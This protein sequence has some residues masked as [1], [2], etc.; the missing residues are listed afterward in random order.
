MSKISGPFFEIS[1]IINERY[2]ILKEKKLFTT[3]LIPEG[4]NLNDYKNYKFDNTV[5]VYLKN[6]DGIK[7][8]KKLENILEQYNT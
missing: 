6:K 3:V 1:S 5:Q 4:I 7:N 2:D 8:L